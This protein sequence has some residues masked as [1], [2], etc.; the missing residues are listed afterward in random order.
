MDLRERDSES[1]LFGPI[2]AMDAEEFFATPLEVGNAH[3][4]Y[5]DSLL[6][7]ADQRSAKR[8]E[9]GL[10]DPPTPRDSEIL[11]SSSPSM[12]GE[13]TDDEEDANFGADLIQPI[14][15]IL[16]YV[17][18]DIELK[19]GRADRFD[20]SELERLYS[21]C[22]PK[23]IEIYLVVDPIAEEELLARIYEHSPT[24]ANQYHQGDLVIIKS[25]EA[26]EMVMK[27]SLGI[28]Y[29]STRKSDYLTRSFAK[30]IEY[31]KFVLHKKFDTYS[32][33]LDVLLAR[34]G[35]KHPYENDAFMHY[36][37]V[38]PSLDDSHDRIY[39]SFYQEYLQKKLLSHDGNGPTALIL[40]PVPP[41]K[42]TTQSQ[43]QPQSKEDGFVTSD[44][45]G[46]DPPPPLSPSMED[47]TRP[48]Q[49]KREKTA[50]FRSVDQKVLNIVYTAYVDIH[51]LQTTDPEAKIDI[52]VN[53][54]Q[55]FAIMENCRHPAI[56]H[57]Y[58]Y[59]CDAEEDLMKDFI[60]N[61]TE[62]ECKKIHL[63]DND[64]QDTFI[65]S[66]A[67]A[68]ANENHA[69]DIIYLIRA[70]TLIDRHTSVLSRISVAFMMDPD[71]GAKR[72]YSISRMERGINGKTMKDPRHA[73][74]FYA[75]TQD[76]YIFRAPM[77]I[78][79]MAEEYQEIDFYET[80][81]ELVMNRILEVN[82]YRLLNDVESVK[83]CRML[84]SNDFS[85]RS[86][87][88]RELVKPGESKF[89]LTKNYSYLPENVS[90]NALS[91]DDMIEKFHINEE[92]LYTLKRYIYLNYCR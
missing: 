34:R 90:L 75:T 80:H 42:S 27:R 36:Y 56:D 70:D 22:V 84:T 87:D 25:E 58:V 89:C 53:N 51:Y 60:A 5:D 24:L 91:I 44:G 4:H 48:I 65:L 3:H 19:S 10:F 6:L 64:Y 15:D 40:P 55:K 23:S 79:N 17:D 20:L 69:H 8:V 68:H 88:K 77:I 13:L 31:N 83:I 18:H 74:N 29:F 92:D 16:V 63:L 30:I 35:W 45:G 2:E 61:L 46:I 47:K 12:V 7:A 11:S 59:H 49:L 32:A 33:L 62:E 50:I 38:L 66:K 14:T 28:F 76:L 9:P 39:N 52:M 78:A 86:L 72:A 1:D 37:K 81:H 85:P 21:E 41:V 73:M 71:G 26:H 54:I 67:V 43:P 82:E 57:V